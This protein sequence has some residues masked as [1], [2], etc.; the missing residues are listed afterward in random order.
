MAQNKIINDSKWNSSYG[1]RCITDFKRTVEFETE[2]TQNEIAELSS[3][4]ETDK[5]GWTDLYCRKDNT[6]P[7]LVHFFCTND[8]SD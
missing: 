7:K 8:S 5:P 2:P 1:G 6:N 3:Q 4:F